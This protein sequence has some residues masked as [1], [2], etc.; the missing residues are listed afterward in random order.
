MSK[1]LHAG[2]DGTK[3]LCVAFNTS[4]PM[5]VASSGSDGVV[6]FWK[7][8]PDE[9]SNPIKHLVIPNKPTV[10]S[11][12]FAP[13]SP[14]VNWIAVAS[15]DKKIRIYDVYSGRGET[16]L[17]TFDPHTLFVTSLAWFPAGQQ[18][19]SAGDETVY[20]WDTRNIRG[21]EVFPRT[22]VG[23][24]KLVKTVAVSPDG[25][26]IASGSNDGTVRLWNAVTGVQ[27]GSTL[28]IGYPTSAGVDIVAFSP[29]GKVLSSAKTEGYLWDMDYLEVEEGI[30]VI[31]RVIDELVVSS[32][33]Q[34]LETQ[35][36][37]KYEVRPVHMS[38]LPF[39]ADALYCTY[40]QMEEMRRTY[41]QEL[42][43]LRQ[44]LVRV[45]IA[46][47]ERF[48]VLHAVQNTAMKTQEEEFRTV[49]KAL[50]DA[51]HTQESQFDRERAAWEAQ[52]HALR[53]DLQVLVRKQEKSL[54]MLEDAE[55]SHERGLKELQGA[56]KK[57]EETQEQQYKDLKKGLQELVTL[58]YASL[59]TIESARRVC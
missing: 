13:G 53:S 40:D 43:D 54:N 46:E 24:S 18:L 5:L 44:E 20:I 42:A 17:A 59:F 27:I 10:S 34:Q 57:A 48:G 32:A 11:I 9:Y 15:F 12:T 49:Q 6:R 1:I 4:S 36:M 56:Q 14:G 28:S 51:M 2:P 21:K 38:F 30:Q 3:I 23:H 26:Y 52:F 47:E 41:E 33:E 16:P 45:R 39:G 8:G 22:L 35:D 7:L 37:F 29:D 55:K 19:V 31:R 25:R 58:T 50:Q